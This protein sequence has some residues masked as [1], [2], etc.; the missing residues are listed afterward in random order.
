[1]NVALIL[2]KIKFIIPIV[3]LFVFS[4]AWTN[5]NKS[6]STSTAKN[7]QQTIASEINSEITQELSIQ[8]NVNVTAKP[9]IS[10]PNQTNTRPIIIILDPGHGGKDPGAVG[11]HKTKEKTVVL[12]IAKYLQ[13]ELN[14]QPNTKAILTR[15]SDYFI[16][17]RQRL[18]IARNFHGDIF[19]SIHADAYMDNYAQGASIYALSLRGATSE[20]ARFLAKKENES[21]LGHVIANKNPVLQSV[22]VDL[23]QTASISASLDMG[24]TIIHELAKFSKL[25]HEAVEQAAFVV[26]KEPDI[27]SLLVET[28][29]ISNSKEEIKLR[30]K[31]YQIKIA[32]ALAAGIKDYFTKHPLSF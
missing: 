4:S 28:G 26:L 13:Q 30:D 1:M 10:L 19:L 27:P 23:T 15:N 6:L 21:E 31:Q 3:L 32:R 24:Y 5:T 14:K 29:F 11:Q 18:K 7:K 25:H 2:K 8:N 22:L 9:Q 16:P 20:A 17:L 12:A